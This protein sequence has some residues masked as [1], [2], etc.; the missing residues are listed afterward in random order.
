M[1]IQIKIDKAK[2]L[3]DILFSKREHHD[4]KWNRA[5][6]RETIDFHYDRYKLFND[7]S[8]RVYK[9][10]NR[11]KHQEKFG[12]I[13]YFMKIDPARWKE[14][15]LSRREVGRLK[16][17]S[18]YRISLW[19]FQERFNADYGTFKC[20]KCKST[21]YHSP[22]EVRLGTKIEYSCCCGH[23]VNNM[24]TFNKQETIYN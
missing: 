7:L 17:E 6:K 23:C 21:F 13:P 18:N 2:A 9:L 3:S 20:D 10:M 14:R 1:D 5:R 15:D 16:F 4:K 12:E 19:F 11:I 24:L 22:S 8:W